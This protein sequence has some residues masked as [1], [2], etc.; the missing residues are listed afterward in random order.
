VISS[1]RIER[2]YHDHVT[3][4]RKYLTNR[5]MDMVKGN[6]APRLRFDLSIGKKL[7]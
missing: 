6:H 5:L 3:V 2:I 7:G 1:D 4:H